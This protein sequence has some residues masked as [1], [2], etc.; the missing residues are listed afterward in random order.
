MDCK[1]ICILHLN[2]IG[3]LVF[4]LPLLKALRDQFPQAVIHSIVKPYLAE[5]L[6]DSPYVD[7]ISFRES[8]FAAKL[9][10]LKELRKNN[11]DLLISLSRS[12]ECLGMASFSNA[13]IKAGFPTFPWKPFFNVKETIAGHNSWYNNS[14]LLKALGIAV[15]QND[16]VG[17]MRIDATADTFFLPERFVVISP[18]ASNRR[19]T[20]AWEEE[21][22]ADLIFLLYEKFSLIPVLVGS[23]DNV[24]PNKIIEDYVTKKVGGDKIKL[25]NFSGKINLQTLC[26]VIKKSALF[27]GIDSGVMHLASSLDIPVVGLFGPTDPFYVGPQNE[28]SIVVKNETLECAPCY[29]KDC[30]HR[31]CMR[32]ISVQSVMNACEKLLSDQ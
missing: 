18:G 13:G 27:V 8:G 10:L 23:A 14:K 19:L 12:E 25:V 22:F 4:S 26:A 2:Q 15:S 24:V 21:K 1:K 29:L 11:Y 3:D 31:N 28:K 20:K 6:K 30:D 16:Y 17:L 9:R 32:L 5:L 7:K